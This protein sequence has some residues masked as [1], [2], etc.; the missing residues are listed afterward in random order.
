[1]ADLGKFIIVAFKKELVEDESAPILGNPAGDVTLVPLHS[2]FDMSNWD[3]SNSG[4]C[5]GSTSTSMLRASLGCRTRQKWRQP[6]KAAAKERLVL[7]EDP[8]R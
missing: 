2:D 4:R 1:M 6:L 3:Q 5:F 7:P 8:A